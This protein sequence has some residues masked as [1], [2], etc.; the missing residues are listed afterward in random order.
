MAGIGEPVNEILSIKDSFQQAKRVLEVSTV[1]NMKKIV[2]YGDL[3]IYNL[4]FGIKDRNTLEKYVNEKIG[5]LLEYDRK[6]KGS[7]LITLEKFLATK[8][9]IKKAAEELFIH[10]KTMEYRLKKI[11]EILGVDLS[12][13]EVCLEL[14]IAI[15]IYRLF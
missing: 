2:A 6:R 7:L 15:K 12:D 5:I 1:F 8:S 10:V 14:N 11:E 4:I 13:S 3:G 9:V